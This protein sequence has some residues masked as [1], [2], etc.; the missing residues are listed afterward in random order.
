MDLR[1]TGH[2]GVESRMLEERTGACLVVQLLLQL[3]LSCRNEGRLVMIKF[4]AVDSP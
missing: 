2:L 3:L 4:H 1:C